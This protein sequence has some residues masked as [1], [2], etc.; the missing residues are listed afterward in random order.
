[1]AG[2]L[3]KEALLIS[4]AGGISGTALSALIVFPFSI[5]IGQSLQLPYVIPEGAI[6]FRWLL[7]SLLV[8]FAAGPLAAAI[9]AWRISR[10]DASVIL[11]EGE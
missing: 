11:R 4:L 5:A 6:I 8:T 7:I 2:L 1:M 3:L 9:S 10:I